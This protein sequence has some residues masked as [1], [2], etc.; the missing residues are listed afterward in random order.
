MKTQTALEPS[1]TETGAGQERGSLLQRWRHLEAAISRRAF[2]LFE[3]RG[4]QDGN[5]LQ[6]WLTAESELLLPVA[7]QM[8][9]DDK[10]ATVKLEAPGF[11]KNDIK[12]AIEDGRL[13]IS[14][15][16]RQ[17]QETKN[18]DSTYR[19]ESSQEFLRVL[20]LPGAVDATKAEARLEKGLLT[21]TLPR[22]AGD[23]ST[24]TEI[25]V[26]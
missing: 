23:E 8:T 5:D 21:L 14:G 13:L 12:V 24:G 25:K 22:I 7:V 19:S 16:K 9:Q 2:E 6:D 17:S 4:Q 15:I 11:S 20:D 18:A 3:H 26:Q 1:A 10:A